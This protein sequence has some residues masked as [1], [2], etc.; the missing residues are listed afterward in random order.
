VPSL[1]L[2]HLSR[3]QFAITAAF[4]MT[5]P[6][7]TVG[8]A[9]FLCGM[10]AAWMRTRNPV[11][12][13]IYRF[14]RR[15]FA[16]GFALGVV[17]GVVLTFEFGLNWGGYA[18]AVGPV[19]GV[20]IA[21]EVVTAFFLEA[22]FIGILLYGEGRV[23]ERVTMLAN[24]MVALGTL[25]SV[26]WIL[27]AN[28]WMQ[29]PAGTTIVNGQFV[30]TNWWHTIF[31]PSFF[32]RFL[33]MLL[34]VLIASAWL[35]AGVSGYYLVRRRHIFFA[36]KSFSLTMAVLA[37]LMPIQ[38][39]VGDYV[40][41]MVGK[42]QPTKLFAMEGNWTST[43]TGWNVVVVPDISAGKNHFMLT[44]PKL[45]S[46]FGKDLSGHTAIPGLLNVPPALRPNTWAVFY[47]FRVMVFAGLF[48]LAT[49]LV[50]LC[51][52][53]RGRLYVSRS[54]QRWVTWM[55]PTGVLTIVAGWVTAEAG[56]Q[57]FVVYGKLLT[58]QSVSQLATPS[59]VFS[60][61][62]FLAVYVLL[63][64]IWVAYLVRR[65]RR[66]PRPEDLPTSGDT[67]I[68]PE[69]ESASTPPEAVVAVR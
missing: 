9:I 62:A 30:P 64:G 34:A 57:P 21:M 1:T 15:I 58:S 20:I 60:L 25:L 26:T 11:Y 50:G 67:V 18:H 5:F 52:K 37:L 13:Q 33:H 7:I 16:V 3:W 44:I 28:S 17:A 43:N 29:T 40:G 59:L 38:L 22:G 49:A 12:L 24:V 51:L 23:S 42:Y 10:Y 32:P 69:A 4:H 45:G 53:A 6:A 65:V 48:M 66:G 55:T 27:A 36:R 56:R 54:F 31:N 14:W 68:E 61:A 63:V 35:V 19:V 46:Y 8:L 39:Y 41:G 2:L 47:G